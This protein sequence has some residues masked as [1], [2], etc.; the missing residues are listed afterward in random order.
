MQVLVTVQQRETVACIG[1]CV[2]RIAA[3]AV[4][5]GKKCVVA[6]VLPQRFVKPAVTTAAT[7]PRY[8]DALAYW[9]ALDQ[10]SYLDNRSQDFMSHDQWRLVGRQLTVC[11]MQVSPSHAACN[12][13]DQDFILLTYRCN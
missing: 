2:F 9:Q 3:V 1:D 4:I 11:N 8:T 12:D 10:S 6:Q 13:A 7:Q 5:S